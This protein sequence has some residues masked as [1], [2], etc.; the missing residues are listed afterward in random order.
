V[1][2]YLDKRVKVLKCKATPQRKEVVKILN[3]KSDKVDE[4]ER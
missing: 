3:G 2:D 4:I 1:K